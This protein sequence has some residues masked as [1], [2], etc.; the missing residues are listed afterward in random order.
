MIYLGL[1]ESVIPAG[2]PLHHQILRARPL[3][4]GNSI[5]LSIS[6]EWDEQRAPRG[7]R[8]ITIS[9]HTELEQWWRIQAQNPKAYQEKRQHLKEKIL[10]VVETLMPGFRQHTDLILDGTPLTFAQFTGRERGWVGGFP[11]INLFQGMA[12]RLAKNLWMVGD[13]IFPGQSTTA[14]AL[15]GL[16]VAQ[17][18]LNRISRNNLASEGG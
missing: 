8:A 12:P 6:P 15:G 5:F 16:R 17:G 13:S 2:F 14:V 4:E 9:T 7:K 11:Q 3:A 1:N 18:V 10:R